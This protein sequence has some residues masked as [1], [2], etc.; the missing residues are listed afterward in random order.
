MVHACVAGGWMCVC[1]KVVIC[2]VTLLVDNSDLSLALCLFSAPGLVI[3]RASGPSAQSRSQ[4]NKLVLIHPF[5]RLT[6]LL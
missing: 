5:S 3:A 2:N 1:D 4:I 6:T